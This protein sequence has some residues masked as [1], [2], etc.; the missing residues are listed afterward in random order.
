MNIKILENI[1]FT[2]LHSL[3][4]LFLFLCLLN[5]INMFH[6]KLYYKTIFVKYY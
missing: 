6:I 4:H 2:S 1:T 5:F 3:F